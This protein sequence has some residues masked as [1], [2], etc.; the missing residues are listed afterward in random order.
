VE[1]NTMCVWLR[2]HTNSH[3]IEPFLHLRFFNIFAKFCTLF[4]SGEVVVMH[5]STSDDSVP[6][7]F[8]DDLGKGEGKGVR[9]GKSESKVK[10]KTN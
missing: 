10:E 1:K 7:S 9:E 5:K 3:F 8:T 6:R 4:N 2:L